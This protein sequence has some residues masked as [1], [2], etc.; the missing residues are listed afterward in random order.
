MGIFAG[1][2]CDTRESLDMKRLGALF[3]LTLLVLL[4]PGSPD[5]TALEEM[6][7][8]LILGIDLDAN[9]ELEF[10][11]TAPVFNKEARIKTEKYETKEPSL[12]ASRIKTDTKTSSLVTGGKFQICLLGSRLLEHEDWFTLFDVFYRDSKFAASTKIVAVDG[13]VSEIMNTVMKDKPPLPQFLTKLIETADRRNITVKTTLQQLHRQMFEKGLTP[14]LAYIDK[15]NHIEVI[16]SALLSERGKL[17]KSLDPE[18][19]KLLRVLQRRNKKEIAFIVDIPGEEQKGVID[20]GK[21]S[22]LPD[23][24]KT[25]IK[26]SHD[27]GKFR[28][29]IKVNLVGA[30]SERLFAFE[31]RRRGGELDRKIGEQLQKQLESLLDKFK[32]SGIDPVGFGLYARAYQYEAWKQVQDDWGKAFAEAETEVSVTVKTRNMGSVK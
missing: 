15:N 12:R 28:F 25:D 3:I 1:A 9:D 24:I 5:K 22:I 8:G 14:A 23:S 11:Y 13:P 29:D 31:N 18:E 17:M 10:Y 30:L 32:K 16:G 20:T 7:I 27:G 2:P 26:C 21:L 19:N 4:F 6:S